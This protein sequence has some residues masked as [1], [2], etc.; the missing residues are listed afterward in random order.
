[1]QI[2]IFL[3]IAVLCMEKF[4]AVCLAP[5]VLM[6]LYQILH[7]IGQ[8]LHMIGQGNQLMKANVRHISLEV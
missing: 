7:M 3:Y 8:V 5:T 6:G 4:M 2:L 1:M